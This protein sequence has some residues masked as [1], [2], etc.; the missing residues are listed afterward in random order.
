MLAAVTDLFIHPTFFKVTKKSANMAP[1]ATSSPVWLVTGVSS[2]FGTLIAQYALDAGHRVVGTV[3]SKTKSAAVTGPL[4]ARGLQVFELDYNASQTV[5]T[6]IVTRDI[7]PAV[8][9]RIDVLVN[10]GA[11]AALGPLEGYE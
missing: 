6:G 10:N 5:I 1:A 8:G 11:Y 2:G 3:R 4:E 9:G 7:L